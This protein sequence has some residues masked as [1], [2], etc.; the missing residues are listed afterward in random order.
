MQRKVS[1]LIP[2]QGTGLGFGGL[3]P[4]WGCERGNCEVYLSFFSLPSPLSKKIL[5]KKKK[6]PV[7]PGSILSCALSFPNCPPGRVHP[8]RP[9]G[10]SEP[11]L[12]AGPGLLV[13]QGLR[14]HGTEG[15][16][17]EESVEC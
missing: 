10:P 15:R 13:M 2:I 17:P 6:K 12:G 4:G 14:G 7:A 3:V 8:P 1:G 16:S 9:A 5:K 11:S